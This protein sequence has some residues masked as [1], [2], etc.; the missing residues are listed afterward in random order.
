[1]DS[2]VEVNPLK[3]PN[4]INRHITPSYYIRTPSFTPVTVADISMSSVN[5][6]SEV[7]PGPYDNTG[8][9]HIWYFNYISAC[10]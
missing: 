3:T 5:G 2:V 7:L 1:M 9:A 10:T 6:I 8:A 4:T